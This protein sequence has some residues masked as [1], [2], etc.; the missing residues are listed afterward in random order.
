MRDD[1]AALTPDA[2]SAL[3][4]IGLLKRAQ[5]MIAT[6]LGPRVIEEA[7]DGVVSATFDDDT[8]IALAPKATLA[9]ARCSC[10]AVFVCRHGL[11]LVLAYQQKH[12]GGA[13]AA[14]THWN[15]GD[16]PDKEVFA[17]IGT[18][19]RGR[20][21]RLMRGGIVV[22]IGH[23]PHPTARLPTCTLQFLVP[24]DLTHARCDCELG[25][26][27]E[28]VLIGVRAF[29]EAQG[30]D[31][32]T[33]ELAATGEVDLEATRDARDLAHEV[34]WH[35]MSATPE[36]LDARFERVKQRLDADGQVWP[37]LALDNLHDALRWYRSRSA[38]Y[39]PALAEAAAELE[40][41]CRAADT[42]SPSVPIGMLLGTAAAE[43][44]RLAELRL[45]SLGARVRSEGSTT[46]AD[47]FL[48]DPDTSNVLVL[49]HTFTPTRQR[50]QKTDPAALTGP[51]LVAREVVKGVR[52]GDVAA[53]QLLT[54]TGR[55]RA[56]RDL[57]LSVKAGTQV[58]RDAGDWSALGAP[59]RLTSMAEFAERASKRAPSLLRPRVLAENLHVLKIQ[60]V[61]Q[62]MW[63]PGQQALIGTVLLESG[64][65]VRIERRHRSAAPGAIAVLASTL[66]TA[67]TCWMSGEVRATEAGLV[68]SPT[69]ILPP[70]GTIVV[71]DLMVD[72]GTKIE[73]GNVGAP[74]S[75]I[76]AALDQAVAGMDEAAH[77]GLLQAGAGWAERMRE[78]QA[79][80]DALGLGRLSKIVE[81]ATKSA[82]AA[83]VG[84]RAASPDAPARWMDARIALVLA[85]ELLFQ[86]TGNSAN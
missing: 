82:T 68:I 2:L 22:R 28:H 30:A 50:W 12:G 72:A 79:Q 70:S 36:A 52:L 56:N 24:N 21:N 19:G 9:Q 71:P 7:D 55:R 27:C 33:V 81:R 15:P 6:G 20:A 61:Q 18:L 54:Q 14:P 75:P 11:S 1:L 77:V 44:T 58:V 49:R 4:S 73:L 69:A 43:E 32:A 40:A 8:T 65:S 5:R 31:Q 83:R 57:V 39:R 78:T 26:A 38:R 29:R 66:A 10:G 84:G 76:G 74:T 3:S 64:E 35:G 59:V 51:E 23:E 25:T 17:L 47:V 34:L 37:E 48:V 41:R 45:I 60:E 42:T 46:L 67:G 62:L 63:S 16:I 85:R 86:P 80:L 53:G 13:D